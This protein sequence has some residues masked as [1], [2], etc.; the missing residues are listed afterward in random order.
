MKKIFN[1]LITALLIFFSPLVFAKDGGEVVDNPGYFVTPGFISLSGAN[2]YIPKS[3]DTSSDKDFRPL[4]IGMFNVI[5][6]EY[7]NLGLSLGGFYTTPS[8]G[9]GNSQYQYRIF[10]EQFTGEVTLNYFTASKTIN[11]WAGIGY[12]FSYI[13]AD[14]KNFKT[15]SGFPSSYSKKYY[16]T[17]EGFHFYAGFE[18]VIT[19]DGHWGLLLMVRG[20]Y[21]DPSYFN[22]EGNVAFSDAS[23]VALSGKDKVTHSVQSYS[24]GIIYHF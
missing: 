24:I 13:E 8:R 9:V 10:T 14:M 17:V 20:L 6:S 21:I 18:Y 1:L 12:N 23:N 3:S 2:S 5:Q 7:G 11:F 4:V 15:T 22:K 19:K 16:N